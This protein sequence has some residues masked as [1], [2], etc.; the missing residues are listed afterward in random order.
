[1]IHCPIP[2]NWCHSGN[3]KEAK[4]VL[5]PLPWRSPWEKHDR[6]TSCLSPD[7]RVKP[8]LSQLHS[9]L[10]WPYEEKQRAAAASLTFP[11]APGVW[12]LDTAENLPT[13]KKVIMVQPYTFSLSKF[14]LKHGFTVMFRPLPLLHL[15]PP[16]LSPQFKLK[17]GSLSFMCASNHN[18]K[19]SFTKV[20]LSIFAFRHSL[21]LLTHLHKQ[22]SPSSIV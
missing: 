21:F 8:E 1:M 12:I 15:S 10:A 11:D 5:F 16:A 18:T 22:W 13:F 20:Y 7:S 9:A 19:D 14:T 6:K 4:P 3:R 17:S 2:L